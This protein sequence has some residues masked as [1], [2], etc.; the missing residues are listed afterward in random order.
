MQL[1]SSKAPIF[2]AIDSADLDVATSWIQATQDYVTGFKLGLEF[3]TAFGSEGVKKIKGITDADIF[4]DLKLHDIP[5]T[6]AGA[7]RQIAQLRPRFLTVHASG[8]RAMVFAA[9]KEGPEIE[10]AAVTVLTSLSAEDLGEI[11]FQFAPLDAAVKLAELAKS[12]GARAIICS[13]HEISAI[14]HAVGPELSIIT[15][16]VRPITS[17]S[18]DDQQR[19]MD[20]KSAIAAGATYLVIGRPITNAWVEGFDALRERAAFIASQLN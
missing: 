16:G 6:V 12:G 3:F 13:P 20:P 10:I 17:D 11:G 8:G 5:H 19:T 2:L 18:A 9:V 7:T 1:M 15:P 14:R 4:L